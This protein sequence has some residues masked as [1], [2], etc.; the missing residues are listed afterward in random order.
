MT[1][2]HLEKFGFECADLGFVTDE[3]SSAL[4]LEA[5]H[6][7]NDAYGG[8]ISFFDERGTLGGR[9]IL[10]ANQNGDISGQSQ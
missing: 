4:D 2:Y 6:R 9:L 7:F 10:Y 8:D 5:E 3:L 1:I